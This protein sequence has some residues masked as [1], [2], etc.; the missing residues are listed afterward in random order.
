MHTAI[1]S[2]STALGGSEK[3]G[4]T[5]CRENVP[6]G[7]QKRP[8]RAS[9]AKRAEPPGCIWQ[10]CPAVQRAEDRRRS[11]NRERVPAGQTLFVPALSRMDCLDVE[12]IVMLD[13]PDGLAIHGCPT[14]P[15]IQRPHCMARIQPDRGWIDHP[16]TQRLRDP[17][18][19]I[20]PDGLSIHGC[21]TNPSI[22][23]RHKMA[24]IDHPWTQRPSTDHPR[25]QRLRDSLKDTKT[26]SKTQ[27]LTQRHKDIHGHHPGSP[28]GARWESLYRTAS[29]RATITSWDPTPSP[30]PPR[31]QQRAAYRSQ[32]TFTVWV[33]LSHRQSGAEG[34]WNQTR[35]LAV[36]KCAW[37]RAKSSVR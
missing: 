36:S 19:A 6:D 33:S 27:R 17:K 30:P 12:M 20:A 3:T 8:K 23:H 4:F 22:Q 9:P 5:G 11:A 7:R 25:T 31:L 21:L 37:I 18:T 16:R 14:D 28:Q 29:G 2:C 35:R 13:V 34:K 24:R 15:S 26:H 10:S 1:P 32:T